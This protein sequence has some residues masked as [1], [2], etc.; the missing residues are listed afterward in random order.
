MVVNNIGTRQPYYACRKA[1]LEPDRCAGSA[2]IR[3]AYLENHVDLQMVAWLTKNWSRI[4][5]EGDQGQLQV[6]GLDAQIDLAET[7]LQE[8]N[9]LKVQKALGVGWKAGLDE[10]LDE[11]ERLRRQRE[12]LLATLTMPGVIAKITQP[13]DY[14]ELDLEDQRLALATAI[15]IVFVRQTSRRGPAS[16]TPAAIADRVAIVYRPD[17]DDVALPRPGHRFDAHPFPFDK[18]E[19]LAWKA[20]R[21]GR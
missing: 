11:V 9:S 10:R 8:F 19:A 20:A 16:A 6:R 13:E 12:E 1:S 14:L 7:Y 5:A 17:G 15:D 4:M 18:A 3:A 21:E 2:S